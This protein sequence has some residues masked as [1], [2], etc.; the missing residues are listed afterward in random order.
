MKL[1]ALCCLAF[2]AGVGGCSLSGRAVTK[3]ATTATPP[4]VGVPLYA[5]GQWQTA[6]QLAPGTRVLVDVYFP[7]EEGYAPLAPLQ[8]HR[9]LI[10]AYNG[11][12][13]YSFHFRALRVV[14]PVEKIPELAARNRA[15]VYDVPDTTRHDWA[16]SVNYR[17]DHRFGPADEAQF[18]LLGGR[19][20]HRWPSLNSISGDLPDQSVPAL[21]RNPVVKG[22]ATIGLACLVNNA[23]T[24]SGISGDLVRGS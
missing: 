5:C 10:A 15:V 6:N 9:D 24:H 22:V 3:P 2:A 12:I 4:L 1:T 14:M 23:L 8:S 17:D 18:V 21:W 7:S 16:V 19:I 11:R 20:R 13:V